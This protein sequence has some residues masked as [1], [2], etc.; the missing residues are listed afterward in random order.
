MHAGNVT[1]ET[2][3]DTK[4]EDKTDCYSDSH[5]VLQQRSQEARKRADNPRKKSEQD[6]G[7]R[8]KPGGWTCGECLQWF[9]ERESYVSHMKNNHGKVGPRDRN[10]SLDTD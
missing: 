10:H 7:S 6:G 9:A 8:V 2:E 4:D 3:K 1:A 5:S